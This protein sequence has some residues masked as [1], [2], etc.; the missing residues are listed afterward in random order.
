MLYGQETRTPCVRGRPSL[1]GGGELGP[2]GVGRRPRGHA[3]DLE[4]AP[5]RLPVA[6]YRHE[7]LLFRVVG[8]D[9][10]AGQQE[11][12][13]HVQRQS[14]SASGT[15]P[16]E[17]CIEPFLRRTEKTSPSTL[18]TYVSVNPR[19]ASGEKSAEQALTPHSG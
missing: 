7:T 18:I 13:R 3:E 5:E 19:A 8:C 12:R 14:T 2:L 15:A 16:A 9:L 11:E 6:F 1:G 4:A 10:A 17:A